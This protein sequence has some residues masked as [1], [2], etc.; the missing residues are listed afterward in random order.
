MAILSV[1]NNKLYDNK[2]GYEIKPGDSMTFKICNV[3]CAGKLVS[4]DEEELVFENNGNEFTCHP[5]EVT[6]I[7]S[8]WFMRD[9]REDN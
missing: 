8:E 2:N 1:K 7:V 4:V 5:L 6:E 3:R 9:L